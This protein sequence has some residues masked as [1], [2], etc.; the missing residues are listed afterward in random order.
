M[1]TRQ[2]LRTQIERRLKPWYTL[3]RR[4][5]AAG[6]V[7]TLRDAL[8]MSAAQLAAR[9]GISRQAVADLETRERAGTATLAALQKAAEE[10]QCDLVYAL[11]P[12]KGLTKTMEDQAHQAAVQELS[13]V[14]HSMRLEDQA[15][16]PDALQALLRAR[17]EELLLNERQLWRLPRQQG[18]KR[19][20][21]E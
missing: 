14:A 6:W 18:S 19:A 15:T 10:M 1:T 3:E 7:R 5:P 12:R 16:E 20:A 8:G 2:L 4:K 11:V 13:S 9:M 17:V 21:R